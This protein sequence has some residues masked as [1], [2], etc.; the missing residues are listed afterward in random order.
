MGLGTFISI[1]LG[2]IFLVILFFLIRS[3]YLK[4]KK[5]ENL[6][7]TQDKYLR[8]MYETLKYTEQRIKT[9]DANGIF[10]GDDEVGFFFKAIKEVQENLSEYIKFIK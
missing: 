4:N 8:D 6:L 7:Q 9:I 3:L 10:Q 1:Q 2:V 5:L